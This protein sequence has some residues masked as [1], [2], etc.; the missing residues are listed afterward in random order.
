[1]KLTATDP[2]HLTPCTDS[3]GCKIRRDLHTFV[4]Y[5]EEREIKRGYRDNSLRKADFKR[6]A[7]L[8]SIKETASDKE[9]SMVLGWIDA[10][11]SL[12][13]KL[14]FVSYDTKGEYMGRS[15]TEP[16]YPDNYIDVNSLEYDR[17]LA[18][19]LLQ[20]E[21]RIL[22][23]LAEDA[24][25]SQNEFYET[26][27]LGKLEGFDWR[28]CATG[29]IP[30]IE[31]PKVRRFLLGLLSG[32]KTDTWYTT[33]SLIAYLKEKHPLFLIPKHV[34]KQYGKGQ[35]P[36]Y[37]NFHEYKGGNRYSG[38]QHTITEQDRNAFER[39]EGRY[40]ERFLEGIP[41]VLG[42]VDIAYDETTKSDLHPAL[43]QLKA[44]RVK[45]RLAQVCTHRLPEPKVWVQPNIEVYVESDIYPTNVLA[46]LNPIADI[47]KEDRVSILLLKKHKVAAALTFDDNFDVL[48]LLTELS[49]KELPANVV[50]ELKG[51][52]QHANMFTLYRGFGLLEG[53]KPHSTVKPLVEETISTSLHVVRSPDKVFS[54]LEEEEFV[55]LIVHHSNSS[56]KLLPT[57][58]K[59]VFPRKSKLKP[60]AQ[61][62][63][64]MLKRK[65]SITLYF[66]SRD[67]YDIF[68]NK[69]LE[70]KCYVSP[71]K[72]NLTITV[73][74][75]A[76]PEISKIMKILRKEY[77][78]GMTDI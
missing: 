4:S 59:T 44:F 21:T 5:V 52:A 33:A 74:D 26:G 50:T 17:F 7:S 24:S 42:Y 8:M 3:Y 23:S 68:L 15:S 46:R 31:F 60:K 36:R 56:L 58:A 16:S 69:L 32:C 77:K 14:G 18:L 55:P 2:S 38:E 34:K 57:T 78:I 72:T 29:V 28:G 1:M 12:A 67:V 22:N 76:R 6:L 47:V 71:N 63:N 54:R 30:A 35:E 19:S 49:V 73:S 10:V 43:M 65:I 25:C 70:S 45:E 13:L 40:V 51:W 11:D 61:K 41:F 37:G 64:V 9:E 48:S 66:L 20:Q 39:V 62:K 53:S 27:V 75:S